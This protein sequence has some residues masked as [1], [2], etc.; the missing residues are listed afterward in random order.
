MNYFVLKHYCFDF[1]CDCKW[2]K[3]NILDGATCKTVGKYSIF[4]S[5]RNENGFDKGGVNGSGS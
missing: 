4:G 1:V 3:I 5:R 2:Q